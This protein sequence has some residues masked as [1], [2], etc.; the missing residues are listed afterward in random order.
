MYILI[1]KTG[2]LS[3][4]EID[5]MKSFSIVDQS[6]PMNHSELLQFSTPAKD[7]HYWLDAKAVIAL[8]ARSEDPTWTE[9]FWNMLKSVEPYGYSD[10]ASGRVKAHIQ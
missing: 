3:L 6:Q 10:L 7:N 1:N 2:A 5:D 9:Q 4:E 8:S